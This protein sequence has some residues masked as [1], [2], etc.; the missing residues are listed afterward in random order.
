[1]ILD[2]RVARL[3]VI[4]R[5]PTTVTRNGFPEDAPMEWPTE[6][7]AYVDL[8]MYR[9]Q[10]SKDSKYQDRA[11]IVYL[12]DIRQSCMLTPSRANWDPSWTTN[13]ILDRC[14]SFFVNNMQSKYSYQTIY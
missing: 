10:P 11:A 3:R 14:K 7:L 5:L 12:T 2:C 4:F 9:V 13:N 1:M 6:P 8:A